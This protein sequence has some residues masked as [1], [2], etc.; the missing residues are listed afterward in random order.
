MRCIVFTNFR[1]QNDLNTKRKKRNQQK[2]WQKRLG[3][4]YNCANIHLVYIFVI[5][6]YEALLSGVIPFKALMI[7]RTMRKILKDAAKAE[8]VDDK[9]QIVG[10]EELIPTL[11][12]L[13]GIAGRRLN[14]LLLGGGKN[15]Y[16]DSPKMVEAFIRLAR[17]FHI[18]TDE[19]ILRFD[20][21]V[22]VNQTSVEKLINCHRK[23]PYG[24]N[25]FRFL[26]GNYRFNEAVHKPEDLLNDYAIRTHHFAPVGTKGLYPGKVGYAIAKRWLNSITHIGADPYNQV[27][28]GAGLSMSLKSIMTLPPFANAGTPIIWIDDHL[29]RRLHEALGHLKSPP[30]VKSKS[31]DISYRC[32]HQAS[33]EQ[34]RYPKGVSKE[35]IKWTMQYLPR[36]VRGIIMDNLIWD[37]E[38]HKAGVYVSYVNEV[39][40]GK[41]KPTEDVLKGALGQVVFETLD[42]IENMW[43]AKCYKKYPVYKYVKKILPKEK[44]QLFN[45]VI[46]AFHSYLTLLSYWKPFVFLWQSVLPTDPQNDWLFR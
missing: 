2:E 20:E 21:D 15:P 42:K 11:A 5:D 27:I 46:E 9:I 45:Q 22:A 44:A 30:P 32:C 37:R 18:K 14:F 40:Q 43:S 36:L 4:Y 23:L 1:R 24:K 28:S 7:E 35:D 6:G 25:K 12:N 31:K 41:P 26:S 39:I 8:G 17:G 29:K 10:I 3:A 19:V 13:Q 33:F 38:K 34:N 16:Y